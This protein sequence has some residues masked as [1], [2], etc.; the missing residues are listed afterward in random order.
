MTGV[1]VAV[2]HRTGVITCAHHHTCDAS[3]SVTATDTPVML[4]DSQHPRTHPPTPTHTHTPTHTLPEAAPLFRLYG[5]GLVLGLRPLLLC[6]PLMQHQLGG[7]LS[8]VPPSTAHI[9]HT[10]AATAAAAAAVR[11]S[12]ATAATGASRTGSSS[13]VSFQVL[14][15]GLA[16]CCCFCCGCCEVA[17]CLPG[18]AGG[19]LVRGGTAAAAGFAAAGPAAATAAAGTCS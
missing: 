11:C 19:R 4:R 16:A 12:A 10:R 1:L 2:N 13:F 8:V 7:L 3:L 18:A 5:Y 14:G 9:K 17:D 6:A 15:I